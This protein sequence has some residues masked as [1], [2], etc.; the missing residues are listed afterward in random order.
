[1]NNSHFYWFLR[2]MLLVRYHIV[3]IAKQWA[4]FCLKRFID[5]F[6]F[7]WQF[8]MWISST[9]QIVLMNFDVHLENLW[10]IG[11]DDPRISIKI[12][13]IYSNEETNFVIVFIEIIWFSEINQSSFICPNRFYELFS[14]V[15]C[16][17]TM[18]YSVRTSLNIFP[19]THWSRL[20]NNF[21]V[22]SY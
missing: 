5:K 1:M 12:I 18:V 15:Y 13:E 16:H 9:K 3:S 14:K 22:T 7:K 10:I 11:L 6:R 20:F 8:Q 21:L 17:S 4:F 19:V 2:W